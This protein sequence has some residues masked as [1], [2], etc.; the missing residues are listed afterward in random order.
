[1]SVQRHEILRKRLLSLGAALGAAA[2]PLLALAGA[3]TEEEELPEDTPTPQHTQTVTATPSG[4]STPIATPTPEY[5]AAL[6]PE[7][8]TATPEALPTSTATGQA[9]Q[10]PTP[11]PTATELPPTTTPEAAWEFPDIPPAPEGLTGEASLADLMGYLDNVGGVIKTKDFGMWEAVP[12]PDNP[13]RIH[14]DI[15][16]RKP[17]GTWQPGDE[18]EFEQKR[19]EFLRWFAERRNLAGADCLNIIFSKPPDATML[20]TGVDRAVTCPEEDQ[21]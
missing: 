3:C 5:T 20:Y 11:T 19:D 1:M 8:A 10:V 4:T 7:A 6:T 13:R 9:T 16:L 15:E 21:G 2:L 18:A 12:P 14:F 17:G